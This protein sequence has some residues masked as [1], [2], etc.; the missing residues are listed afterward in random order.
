MVRFDI[1]FVLVELGLLIFC[2]VD[3]IS[4]YDSRIKVL[5]KI[6]WVFI[7]ILLPILGPILWLTV[8][9]VR[10]GDSSERLRTSLPPVAPDD[11]PTFLK[12]AGRYED[13]DARIRRLEAELKAL[14]DEK[15]DE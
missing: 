8:G 3:C 5:N 10:K 11:D 4:I 7:I 13:Q 2:L 9:K 12:N 1:L 6:S 14:N 15:S